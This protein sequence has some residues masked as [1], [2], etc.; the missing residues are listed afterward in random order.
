[1]ILLIIIM[2]KKVWDGEDEGEFSAKNNILIL[3]VEQR[4]RTKNKR[5][6]SYSSHYSLSLFII[7]E[8]IVI[9]VS[10]SYHNLSTFTFPCHL[11]ATSF[12]VIISHK[13][14]LFYSWRQ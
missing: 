8:S 2:T 1:M 9:I 4:N 11:T 6:G 12:R 13:P 3:Q 7:I 5:D 14:T 10:K